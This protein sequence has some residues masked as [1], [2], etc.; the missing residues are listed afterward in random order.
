MNLEIYETTDYSMF[1]RLVGNREVKNYKKIEES[2]KARGYV[3]NPLIVNEKY[4]VI[5]GQNRLKALSN[6]GMP[7]HYYVV[8]GLGIDDARA[9]NL[10]GTNWKPITYVKSYAESGLEPYQRLVALLDE[11]E[12]FSLQE[13]VGV[14]D[15]EIVKSGWDIKYLNDG[16]FQ[17]D[18]RAEEEARRIL[19]ILTPL[20][21][22][23][24]KMDGSKRTIVTGLAWCIRQK[25]CDP[26]RLIR[27]IGRNYADGIRAVVKAE[28]F[29]YDVTKLYNKSLPKEKR[30][31][32]DVIYR[33]R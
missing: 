19:N 10:N 33:N 11:Y 16:T 14:V 28:S 22:A 9:L 1:K 12:E 4:E 25:G 30:I 26:E 27:V 18:K 5:D 23:I 8:E 6:L 31:D 13:V 15:G 17:M 29:L 2:I 3:L 32:F 24:K 21:P 20:K 7:V